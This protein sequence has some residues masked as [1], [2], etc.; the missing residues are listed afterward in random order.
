[1]LDIPTIGADEAI[2]VG[3]IIS[4]FEYIPPLN[5]DVCKS[6]IAASLKRNLPDAV[7][8]QKLN[9]I[10][11]GPSAA[12]AK[13]WQMDGP[14][15]ALNSAIRLFKET[16]LYPKYFAACDPQEMVADLLP[17]SPPYDTIY[18]IASKCHPS[19][20]QKLKGRD[21]RLWHLRDY[22]ADGRSRIALCPSVTLSATW[23]MH[24]MGYTDFE[25]YGWDGCFMD[26]KHHAAVDDDW[27]SFEHL[28]VNYG[29]KIEGSE[30]IGG[31][32]FLTTRSWVA[33]AKA[34]EQFFQLADYFDLRLTIHGDGMFAHARD[35][36]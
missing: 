26:G 34:A 8:R 31:K 13:L 29:G 10:A 27:S 1:M 14:V 15:L 6:Q 2:P 16:G 24:R 18:L 36:L 12:K 17:D 25:Y 23:L 7:R 20:F 22:D 32:T 19:V 3:S 21:V 35:F 9:I 28:E 30:V 11:G 4:D 33:E 5:D